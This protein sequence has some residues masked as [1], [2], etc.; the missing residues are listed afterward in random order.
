MASPSL[1][2]SSQVSVGPA[3]NTSTSNDDDDK[4]R[5]FS[6]AS[7]LESDTGRLLNSLGSVGS[8]LADVGLGLTAASI[9]KEAPSDEAQ[10]P[11]P[12]ALPQHY[13]QVKL[14][15]EEPTNTHSSLPLPAIL[16]AEESS[17]QNSSNKGRHLPEKRLPSKKRKMSYE[18]YDSAMDDSYLGLAA[19]DN[20]SIHSAIIPKLQPGV[21]SASAGSGTSDNLHHRHHYHNHLLHGVSALD[22]LDA[23]GDNEGGLPEQPAAMENNPEDAPLAAG[24]GE[25]DDASDGDATFTSSGHRLLMEAIMMTGGLDMAGGTPARKRFESWGGMS[26]LSVQIGGDPTD[27]AMALASALHHTGII[28]DVTAAA[29]FGG[30][31]VDS[32]VTDEQQLM[33]MKPPPHDLPEARDRASSFSD[34]TFPVPMSLDG[35]EISSDLQKFVAAAVASVGD[36]LAELAGNIEAAAASV[37]LNRKEGGSEV[38]SIATPLMVGAAPD[39]PPRRAVGDAKSVSRNAIAVDYDAVAAAVDAA[40]AATGDLDLSAIGDGPFSVLPGLMSSTASSLS[41]GA[42][43]AAAAAAVGNK[44]KRIRKLPTHSKSK[45]TTI[46]IPHST[47]AHVHNSLLSEKDQE[48]IRERARKAAGYVPPSEMTEDSTTTPAKRTLPPLKKRSKRMTPEAARGNSHVTP[49]TSNVSANVTDAVPS[50]VVSSS[51]RL[52]PTSSSKAGTKEKSTQKWDSMYDA[53]LQFKQDRMDE[54]T[55]GATE[56]AVAEW[57]WDGNVPTTYKTKDG[58]ALGRWINNQRSA[59]SKGTL[60]DERETRLLNS[61]LK[62]SVLASN[63]FN[64]MLEE[65]RIYI[66]EYVSVAIC[67]VL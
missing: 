47:N 3:N 21:S 34:S 62:W 20:N 10:F 58:K 59:K 27:A 18:S 42:V 44:T 17:S 52:E 14:P 11:V 38:S 29:N 56:E 24:G 49:K 8:S 46:S 36:Q 7:S 57:V 67:A 25:K 22:H 60:K 37:D 51:E 41:S 54:E 32:S 30:G 13:Y 39:E 12:A 23:L 31:S 45:K 4:I 19:L 28:D 35:L 6:N 5:K 40:N 53:L 48:E 63:S 33:F 1:K 9:I 66:K 15:G 55:S 65:L 43:A 50:L 2:A 16:P 61:G 64:E 26:D